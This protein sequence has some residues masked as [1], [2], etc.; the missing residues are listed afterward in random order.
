MVSMNEV[1]LKS[2]S[3]FLSPKIIK[4]IGLPLFKNQ[5]FLQ[6]VAGRYPGAKYETIQASAETGAISANNSSGFCKFVIQNLKVLFQGHKS[7]KYSALNKNVSDEKL[8]VYDGLHG[9]DC[10]LYQRKKCN[11]REKPIL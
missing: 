7:F 1:F 11:E 8:D 6:G 4:F 9:S 5:F 3:E 2:S 10:F